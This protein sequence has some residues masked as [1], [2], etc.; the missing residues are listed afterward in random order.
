MTDYLHM[1]AEQ[2]LELFVHEPFL[3]TCSAARLRESVVY[4]VERQ[5]EVLTP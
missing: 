3:L 2:A 4:L 5:D 1:T